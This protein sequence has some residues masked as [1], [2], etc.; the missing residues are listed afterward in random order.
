MKAK[1]NEDGQL[2]I[3]PESPIEAFALK[4][5][6]NGYKSGDEQSVFFPNPTW[7]T[8]EESSC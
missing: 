4:Q 5:W 2:E 6:S 7:P 1:I 3:T 8:Q